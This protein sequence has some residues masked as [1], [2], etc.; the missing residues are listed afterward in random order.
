MKKA[1]ME[2]V[3]VKEFLTGIALVVP[4]THGVPLGE[5][6]FC[7]PSTVLEVK[8]GILEQR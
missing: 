7:L 6:A 4:L 8:D 1:T 5:Y 2:V 3:V